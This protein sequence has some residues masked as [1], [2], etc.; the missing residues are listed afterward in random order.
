MS[1]TLESSHLSQ[2]SSEEFTFLPDIVKDVNVLAVLVLQQKSKTSSKQSFVKHQCRFCGKV[3]GSD[4]AL[5]IHLQSHTGERPYKCNVCGSRFSTRG[6]LKM[7]YRTHMGEHPY[8]CKTCS[9]AFTTKGNLKTHEAVH[10]S[11]KQHLC[12]MCGKSFSS[13]SA[14]QIHK[15]T[16]T[17][18]RPFACTVCG[19]AFTTK[20]NLKVILLLKIT[21]FFCFWSKKWPHFFLNKMVCVFSVYLK[22]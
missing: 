5:Q 7:H 14:L 11:P 4:S 12:N 18:E 9:Q 8:R 21:S 19:R 13:S 15:R 6:N 20:G 3:F 1:K 17:G 22:R 10:R 16:H 2:P